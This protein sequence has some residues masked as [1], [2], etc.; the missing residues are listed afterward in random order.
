MKCSVSTDDR[1]MKVS[2]QLESYASRTS[3]LG[4]SRRLNSSRTSFLFIN[5]GSIVDCWWKTAMCNKLLSMKRKV[6]KNRGMVKSP[7]LSLTKPSSSP[8]LKSLGSRLLFHLLHIH[9]NVLGRGTAIIGTTNCRCH[10]IPAAAG[11]S[12]VPTPFID[13][14][15]DLQQSIIYMITSGWSGYTSQTPIALEFAICNKWRCG[16]T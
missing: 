12:S 14:N 10:C 2:G 9:H 3:S 16:L 13:G 11:H 6:L 15:C 7:P 8:L 5:E 1:D 4:I